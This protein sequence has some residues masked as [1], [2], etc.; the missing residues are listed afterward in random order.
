MVDYQV[1]QLRLDDFL[2]LLL[3]HRDELRLL[4]KHLTT[5]TTVAM[6]LGF[7]F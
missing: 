1:I 7:H 3:G 6:R 4:L 2:I 5:T